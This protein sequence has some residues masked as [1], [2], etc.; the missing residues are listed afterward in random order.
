MIT[1]MVSYSSGFIGGDGVGEDMQTEKVYSAVYTLSANVKSNV[2][3]TFRLNKNDAEYA[4][5]KNAGTVVGN[6]TV[7]GFT[8]NSDEAATFKM[9]NQGVTLNGLGPG[10]Y[11]IEMLG[12]DKSVARE[13]DLNINNVK[14][15]LMGGITGIVGSI[16]GKTFEIEGDC[17]P[18]EMYTLA[19]TGGIGTTIFYALGSLLI[20]LAVVVF[21]NKKRNLKQ[22][23]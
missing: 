13:I 2:V 6:G 12:E 14:T 8:V 21:I 19:T 20:G 17:V 16:N 5:T 3:G 4:V 9:E 18:V 10:V 1:G 15:S 23:V 11:K 7:T 22:K